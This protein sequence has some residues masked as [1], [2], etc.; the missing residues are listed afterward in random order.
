MKWLNSSYSCR[1]FH[2]KSS[3][4]YH[5]FHQKSWRRFSPKVRLTMQ[6]FTPK[7]A[8][9]I[10][11]L[12]K[13]LFFSDNI[14]LNNM[15]TISDDRSC[16]SFL[17]QIWHQMSLFKQYEP[18]QPIRYK[19]FHQ[20]SWRRLFFLNNYTKSPAED[21][22]FF[23]S[24][25]NLL[26]LRMLSRRNYCWRLIPVFTST[27]RCVVYFSLPRVFRCICDH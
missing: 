15:Q 12:T 9:N 4:W 17:R 26:R 2:Q 21:N 22:S 23:S 16:I 6:F 7:S 13:K 19:H 25:W 11:L 10:F 18:F 1:L 27:Y 3:R 5:F 14:S 8:D 24:I 20:M